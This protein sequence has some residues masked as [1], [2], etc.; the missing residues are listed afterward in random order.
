MYKS[1]ENGDRTYWHNSKSGET[2]SDEDK[3]RRVEVEHETRCSEGKKFV[4][5][6]PWRWLRLFF[7]QSGTQE[8]RL[9]SVSLFRNKRGKIRPREVDAGSGTGGGSGRVADGRETQRGPQRPAADG[10]A[11]KPA[12]TGIRRS[13]A[14]DAKV[15]GGQRL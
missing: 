7:V 12:R 10:L 2:V 15:V 3:T 14:D 8:A 6:V 4:A 13:L 5:K 9:K 1:K 11:L